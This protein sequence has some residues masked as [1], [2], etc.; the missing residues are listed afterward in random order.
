MIHNLDLL[1]SYSHL[2]F[3]LTWRQ[4]HSGIPGQTLRP[5]NQQDY[6]LDPSRHQ[7]SVEY[8]CPDPKGMSWLGMVS[9]DRHLMKL[10]QDDPGCGKQLFIIDKQQIVQLWHVRPEDRVSRCVNGLQASVLSLKRGHRM[11]Q[12]LFFVRC[13]AL[14]LD[15]RAFLVASLKMSSTFSRYLAEHSR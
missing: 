1:L 9:L 7:F 11:T 5:Q 14:R 15:A 13:L 8:H 4:N 12:W 10:N 2:Y 3:G 6:H